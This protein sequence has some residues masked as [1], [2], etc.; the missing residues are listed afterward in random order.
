V[1][2]FLW[3]ICPFGWVISVA[4]LRCITPAYVVVGAASLAI[5]GAPAQFFS[6]Q[7]KP[8]PAGVA[9][10][11]LIPIVSAGG[12]LSG[13]TM[14]LPTRESESDSFANGL[15]YALAGNILGSTLAIGS[16]LESRWKVKSPR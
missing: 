13:S 3:L 12:G 1:H 9:I 2:L 16:I 5:I 15:K 10:R 4:K 6:G 7:D 8:S 14:I 11:F